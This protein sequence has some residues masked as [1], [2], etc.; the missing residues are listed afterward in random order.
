MEIVIT[1]PYVLAQRLQALQRRLERLEEW[2]KA[3]DA[4][5][6]STVVLPVQ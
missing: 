2:V 4:Q 6:P 3:Q 5:K 1:D